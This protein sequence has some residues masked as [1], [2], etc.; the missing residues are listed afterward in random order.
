MNIIIK[1][2]TEE[3]KENFKGYVKILKKYLTF[4]TRIQKCN[5]YITITTRKMKFV[6][7]VQF[8]ACS[9]SNLPDNLTEELH[10]DKCKDCDYSLDYLTAKIYD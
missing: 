1:K 8:M 4:S 6:Y 2:G 7:S 5:K 9:L 10:K 3:S